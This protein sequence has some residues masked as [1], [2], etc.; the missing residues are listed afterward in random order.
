VTVSYFEWLQN[1]RAESWTLEE[2]D[3]RLHTMMVHAYA[4]VR[5]IARDRKI[6]NR[7]AAYVHALTRIETVYK[8]RGIF[9]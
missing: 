6:D 5:R 8:E 3:A 1:R 9:P 7:T 4:T 2:V